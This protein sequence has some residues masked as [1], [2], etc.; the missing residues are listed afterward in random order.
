MSEPI[1]DVAERI[2]ALINSQPRSPRKDEIMSV[3]LSAAQLGVSPSNPPDIVIVG[4]RAGATI[5]ITPDSKLAFEGFHVALR[6]GV[7]PSP[8]DV[9]LAI[10]D[11]MRNALIEWR[12][13]K[14]TLN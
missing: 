4:S 10:L 12:A 2:M 6:Q 14:P 8:E 3:L 7:Q 1:D 5:T 13:G 9:A 11:Y